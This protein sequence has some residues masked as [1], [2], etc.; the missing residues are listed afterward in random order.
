LIPGR[1]EELSS[2]HDPTTIGWPEG[3]TTMRN[4]GVI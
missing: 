3:M 1:T 2:L 4:T